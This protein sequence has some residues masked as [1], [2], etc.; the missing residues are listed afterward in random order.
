MLK[1]KHKD[2]ILKVA[3][4]IPYLENISFKNERKNIFPYRQKQT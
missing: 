2:K 1:D 4:R 3:N